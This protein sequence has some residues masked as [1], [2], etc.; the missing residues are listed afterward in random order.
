MTI[1]EHSDKNINGRA[2]MPTTDRHLF[3]IP[4]ATSPHNVKRKRLSK[5]KVSLNN[6]E[7]KKKLAAVN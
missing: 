2:E 7:W 6:N 5:F 4:R 1:A 3:E